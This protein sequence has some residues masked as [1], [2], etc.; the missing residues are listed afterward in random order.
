M[1]CVSPS[2]E[3]S[4][5][6]TTKNLVYDLSLHIFSQ[7]NPIL[8]HKT[9]MAQAG[10]L[11]SLM[12]YDDD[13]HGFIIRLGFTFG[14][15]EQYLQLPATQATEETC[16]ELIECINYDSSKLDP[17]LKLSDYSKM[18]RHDAESDRRQIRRAI[19]TKNPSDP[20]KPIYFLI[21]VAAGIM[22]ASVGCSKPDHAEGVLA[23]ITIFQPAIVIHPTTLHK[24]M[25]AVVVQDEPSK[26]LTR[27][28]ILLQKFHARIKILFVTADPQE[29]SHIRIGKEHRDLEK[30]LGYG[31]QASK[32]DLQ[33]QQACRRED[34]QQRILDFKPHILNF[35]GHAG[36]Q[37]LCFEDKHGD[38]E[39]IPPA[40]LEKL[41]EIAKE[42]GLE[43][44][45]LNACSTKGQSAVLSR[46]IEYVVSMKGLIGDKNAILFT[47][48]FYSALGPSLT[49]EAAF[50]AALAAAELCG[51]QD[52]QKPQLVI[53]GQAGE[54]DVSEEVVE[55]PHL[56]E[57]SESMNSPLED[58][59]KP[60]ATPVEEVEVGRSSSGDNDKIGPTRNGEP[61]EVVDQSIDEATRHVETLELGPVPAT[62]TS[63]KSSESSQDST[64][65]EPKNNPSPASC[66]PGA[67]Q[68]AASDSQ[69]SAAPTAARTTDSAEI[70]ADEMIALYKIPDFLLLGQCFR[71]RPVDFRAL[72]KKLETKNPPLMKQLNGYPNE[73][74]KLLL[75]ARD[76]DHLVRIVESGRPP[77][78][79]PRPTVANR[80]SPHDALMRDFFGDPGFGGPMFMNH[81]FFADFLR[82]RPTVAA[83]PPN[84]YARLRC[85]RCN[86]AFKSTGGYICRICAGGN[87]LIC[88]TCVGNQLGCA[89]RD[90]RLYRIVL[91]C[92]I[93]FNGWE[94]HGER[95]KEKMVSF[96]VCIFMLTRM[97]KKKKARRVLIRSP[98]FPT[99][100]L[101][102]VS[103]PW[104]LGVTF[105]PVLDI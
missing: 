65:S 48:S 44:V 26:T 79:R 104:Y 84:P 53:R 72:A 21:G 50:N 105:N 6:Q 97:R 35:A 36:P 15:Y 101:V 95:N 40:N 9:L 81:P 94:K 14:Q 52:D 61:K 59:S 32:F 93:A 2:T 85:H 33:Q 25:K 54:V 87:C 43:T 89:S 68:T 7:I 91:Q 10:V 83:R 60:I 4:R 70:N 46:Q 76:L 80:P 41:L 5:K 75:S 24:Q 67:A 37:G 71:E 30:A 90:H 56:L 11:G 49:T 69:Q 42:H 29:T 102:I 45:I 39:A 16:T 57:S 31:Q 100:S 22:Q 103:W 27:V 47:R 23:E 98:V 78:Q 1:A 18:S 62:S 99:F 77:Q 92:G 73:L 66:Q 12:P 96:V 58:A 20:S 34:L 74:V 17:V 13:E 86:E 64:P 38:I 82:P 51:L 63:S 8:H 28:K 55:I 3:L 19:A 88:A